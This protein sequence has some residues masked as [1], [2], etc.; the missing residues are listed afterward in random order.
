MVKKQ[1]LPFKPVREV[2]VIKARPVLQLTDR[3]KERFQSR[4][5]EYPLI[6]AMWKFVTAARGL[7]IIT[8]VTGISA[9]LNTIR[10]SYLKTREV[11]FTDSGQSF[12]IA[13]DTVSYLVGA[14]II[15]GLGIVVQIILWIDGHLELLQD[16]C[17]EQGVRCESV[18]ELGAGVFNRALVHRKHIEAPF[19]LARYIL[20]VVWLG[21]VYFVWSISR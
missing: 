14:G 20:T 19:L 9:I 17:A 8:A 2:R 6:L 18:L 10:S 15:V 3:V 11:I 1:S 16:Q 13:D 7:L 5:I 12:T 4:R 21:W